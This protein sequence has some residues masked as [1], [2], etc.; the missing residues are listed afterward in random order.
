MYSCRARS[1]RKKQELL[2]N[3]VA[4]LPEPNTLSEA[5]EPR[6]RPSVGWAEGLKG[7]YEFYPLKCPKCKSPM[8]IIAFIYD[9]HELE[10]II[11]LRRGY[12]GTSSAF[13]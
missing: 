4:E 2:K 1:E 9:P 13:A 5:L 7:I 8:R 10:K 12:G 3:P 6:G 11:R